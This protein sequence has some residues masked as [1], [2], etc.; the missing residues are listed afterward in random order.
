MCLFCMN[1]AT[2]VVNKYDKKKYLVS[3]TPRTVSVVIGIPG[4]TKTTRITT[5]YESVI[6]TKKSLTI[7][8]TL[9]KPIL[10]VHVVRES[11]VTFEELD[12]LARDLIENEKLEQ[13]QTAPYILWLIQDR[14]GI[15][16]S[17]IGV[18]KVLGTNHI[19]I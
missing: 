3:T 5:K 14:T 8:S 7:L 15:S 9:S 1:K 4:T 19:F 13:I 10:A 16:S 17:D 6:F 11:A 12:S 18:E 2:V